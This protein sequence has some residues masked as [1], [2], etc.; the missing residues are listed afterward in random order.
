M[1]I[2]KAL[3]TII[4]KQI[5]QEFESFYTYLA[6]AAYFENRALNGFAK[7]MRMQ[8]HE[9][10]EHALKF[11]DYL[12]DRGGRAELLTIP[13]PPVE[14]DS[15][16]GV[17]QQSLEQEQRVTESI[18]EIYQMAHQERDYATVSFLKWFSDEQVEEERSAAD[19]VERLKLAGEDPQALLFLD[20]EAGRREM[21]G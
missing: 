7:W 9:E 14:F 19:M 21:V 16:L 18:Y 17:F 10:Y 4:N 15:P 1:T 8:S 11:F 12:N 20:S 13:Q 3:Q 2:S 6:M 5:S